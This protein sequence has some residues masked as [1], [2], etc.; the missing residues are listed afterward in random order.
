[1]SS[2]S[3]ILELSSFGYQ[4]LPLYAVHEV[5]FLLPGLSFF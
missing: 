1:M 2:G 4:S 5:L 3:G